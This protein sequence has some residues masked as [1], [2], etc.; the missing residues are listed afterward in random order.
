M[1]IIKMTSLKRLQKELKKLTKEPVMNCSAGPINDDLYHWQATIMGPTDTPYF[2][3][4]FKLELL[5]TRNYPIKPPQVRFKTKI[6]HPNIDSSGG[7]CVDILKDAWNPL[8][9]IRTILL[10]ICSLLND[11]NPKDPLVP[12]IAELYKNNRKK[13]IEEAKSW[14]TIH[15]S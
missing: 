15:A 4:I 12:Y 2:G 13:F 6:F 3:G 7:I 11:P 10:S 1:I 8:L 9:S 5:F 14:T